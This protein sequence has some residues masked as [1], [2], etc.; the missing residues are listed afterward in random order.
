MPAH[1][2]DCWAD[3]ASTAPASGSDLPEILNEHAGL[4]AVVLTRALGVPCLRCSDDRLRYAAALTSSSW[5][6][7]AWALVRLRERAL[8][9]GED[10][11]DFP[12]AHPYPTRWR[13][14]P[15]VT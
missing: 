11:D 13:V 1:L 8:E 3:V 14:E 9:A 10:G 2:V 4:E 5:S 15:S 12:S 7:F 6:F